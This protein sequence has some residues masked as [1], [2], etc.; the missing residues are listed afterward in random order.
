M[1]STIRRLLAVTSR[2]GPRQRESVQVWVAAVCLVLALVLAGCSRKTASN[3]T[4]TPTRLTTYSNTT[5]RFSVNYDP[6]KFSGGVDKNLSTLTSFDIPG[7]GWVKGPTLGF[8]LNLK[9]A[10][11]ASKSG[12][13][14]TLTATRDPSLKKPTLASFRGEK[15][16]RYLQTHG[17]IVGW[18][19]PIYV[20]SQ[21]GFGWLARPH[22]GPF[23]GVTMADYVVE[24]NGFV[25]FFNLE[26]PTAVAAKVLP[27][28]NQVYATFQ[29]T[30]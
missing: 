13:V 10:P 7:A 21:P 3:P 27:E 26:T 17:W 9:T 4:P 1:R 12:G 19:E 14:F 8:A 16:M 2:R 15:Y 25:Y 29:I 6:T 30:R 28:L 18:P 24:K 22:S 20:D 5:F 23:K 11:G